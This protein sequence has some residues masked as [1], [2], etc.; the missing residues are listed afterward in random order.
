MKDWDD[1]CGRVNLEIEAWFV[2]QCHNPWIKY[3]WWYIETTPEHDGG[4]LIAEAKPVN[5]KYY[6]AGY[7]QSGLTKD[8]NKQ[9]F[10][11]IARGLPILSNR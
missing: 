9:A 10:L 7:L 6:F 3:S 2:K 8:Q 5:E 1:I 11:T 4:F